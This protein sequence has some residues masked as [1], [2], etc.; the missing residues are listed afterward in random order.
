MT[1]MVLL[2]GE[3]MSE[4][5]GVYIF[6]TLGVGQTVVDNLK[7]EQCKTRSILYLCGPIT[8]VCAV[9][10]DIIE[11]PTHASQPNM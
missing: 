10:G 1:G 7:E 11:N 6:I 5:V 4:C 9:L 8:L 2:I 3:S